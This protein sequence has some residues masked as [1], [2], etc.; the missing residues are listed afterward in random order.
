MEEIWKDIPDYEGY[1]QV[2]NLGRVR[3][4]DRVVE[5]HK[6]GLV[7]LKGVLLKHGLNRYGYPFVNLCVNGNRKTIR[8]HQL[9]AMAFMGHE[10][11]GQKL[12][13]DH[14][15]DNPQNNRVD[16]LQ[17][18]TQRFNVFK[19]Q[20]KYS[21]KYKGVCWHKNTNKW[22]SKICINGKSKYLGYF[23]SEEEAHEAYLKAVKELELQNI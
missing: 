17:I 16:N 1:Y 18:V 13:I 14:I 10:P 6:T 23:T 9:V 3:S 15:D 5:H 4:L 12:V 7:N 11:C 22:C 19:T 20:G 2:S 21:S 8:V